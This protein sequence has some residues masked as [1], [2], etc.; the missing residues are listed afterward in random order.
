MAGKKKGKKAG[1]KA[2]KAEK[3]AARKARKAAKTARATNKATRKA[4]KTA[5]AARKAARPAIKARQQPESLR[6]RSAGPSFTV[7]DIHKSL[8]FYCDV[9]G[10]T[11]R[12]RWEA[13]GALKGVELV[14]GSVVFWLGQDDWKKGRDRVKGQGFRMYCSTTQDIDTLAARVKA[15]GA[16]IVEEPKD[17]S[18]GG[19][20][21]GVRD[22]DG[23]TIT[24]ASGF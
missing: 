12:E 24:F 19:R 16:T 3:K 14:A 2:K 15:G 5:A 13:D 8:A 4:P 17:E 7:G 6:L 10:F 9:L 23:F 11:P 22:P 20:A 1:K 18:W 21:F